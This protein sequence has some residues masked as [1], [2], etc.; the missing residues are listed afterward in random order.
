M[1]RPTF[2]EGVGV[3]LA[4]SLSGAALFSALTSWFAPG[5]AMRLLIAALGIAYIL[6]LLRRSRERVG[7]VVV[8]AVWLVAAGI[9]GFLQPPLILYVALHI[10]LIWLIR[11]LYFYHSALASL[12]DL[13]LTGLALAAAVWALTTTASL[14]LG[15]WCFFLVQALFVSIP[16]NLPRKPLA[17]PSAAVGEDRFQHAHRVAQA[18]LRK[19]ASL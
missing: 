7:R 18:A 4:A 5:L 17:V 2:F 13:G 3:G 12:A 8:I 15:L 10:G 19:L 14:L 16:G 9:I 6:Y 1:T 11:S